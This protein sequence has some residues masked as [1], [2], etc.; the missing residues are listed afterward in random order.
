MIPTTTHEVYTLPAYHS[1]SVSHS[2]GSVS[3]GVIGGAVAAGVLVLVI[4]VLVLVLVKLLMKT[5][6]RNKVVIAGEY[7]TTSSREVDSRQ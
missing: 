5:P 2:A 1:L 7:A 3:V 6:R 4:V